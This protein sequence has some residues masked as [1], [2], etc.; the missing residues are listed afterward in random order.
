MDVKSAYIQA[1]GFGKDKYVRPPLKEKDSNGLWKLLV[2][3]YGL[4]DSGRLWYLTL[5]EA[6][7]KRFGFLH[8]KLDPSMYLG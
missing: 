2:P 7:T 6:L 8:S 5:C 3:A 1:R 4:T